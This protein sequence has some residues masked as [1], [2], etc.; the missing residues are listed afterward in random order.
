[1]K[2]TDFNTAAQLVGNQS[3]SAS[4]LTMIAQYHPTL[5]RWVAAHAGTDPAIFPWLDSFGDPEVSRILASRWA[6][7]QSGSVTPLGAFC[8]FV[9]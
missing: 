6:T 8:G 4:D 1:M 9:A 7:L 5:R 3:T 2:L